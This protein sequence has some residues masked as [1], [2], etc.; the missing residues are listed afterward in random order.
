M[1]LRGLLGAQACREG[2]ER[3]QVRDHDVRGEAQPR[4]SSCQEQRQRASE[5]WLHTSTT[6]G[7]RR[8]SPEAGAATGQHPSVERCC[9]RRRRRRCLR[10]A[11][12]SF[13]TTAQRSSRGFL[14]RNAPSHWHGTVSGRLLASADARPWVADA[15]LRGPCAAERRGEGGEPRAAVRIAGGERECRGNLPAAAAA[16]GQVGSGSSD[17][18]N[19][20]SSRHKR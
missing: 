11:L 7:E 19:T 15:G 18:K 1:H 3:S 5:L 10:L 13:P 12:A 14:L 17:V 6:T 4:G 9:C 2:L 16:H 8:P 20:H